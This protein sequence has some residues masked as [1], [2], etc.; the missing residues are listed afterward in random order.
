MI[1][2]L[3]N[4]IYWLCTGVAVI[5]IAAIF[6]VL[7]SWGGLPPT[8]QQHWLFIYAGAAIGIWLFGRAARYIL[9]GR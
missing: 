9:A 3:A 1:E 4:V 6:I 5:P 8:R 7:L 2:R